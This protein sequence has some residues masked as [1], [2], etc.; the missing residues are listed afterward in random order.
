MLGRYAANKELS[1]VPNVSRT[2]TMRPHHGLYSLLGLLPPLGSELRGSD[3]GQNFPCQ[4]KIVEAEA[5]FFGFNMS[6]D[7]SARQLRQES[8]RIS[9]C[10]GA[11]PRDW[12]RWCKL[13]RRLLEKDD[14]T[15]LRTGPHCGD[16]TPTR[17]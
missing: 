16:D 11:D 7:P 14:V 3:T 9:E 15:P 10:P 17:A 6:V 1:R 2:I 5:K 12:W 4:F 13:P 8:C